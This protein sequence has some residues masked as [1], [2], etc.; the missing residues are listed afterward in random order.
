MSSEVEPGYSD[1]GGH[2][3]LIWG[4]GFLSPGGAAE[5]ARTLAGADI[6]GCEVLDVGSGL[7][8]ADI[9]L[10]R[11]HGAASVIGIDVQEDLVELA[12]RR[13]ADAGLDQRID[14]RLVAP[15]SPLPFADMS[16]DVVFSKDSIIH[17]EDKEALYREA[18]RVLRPGGRLFVSDWLRGEAEELT[19]QVG[20]FVEAAGHL[21]TMISLG[22]AA[23]IVERVGFVG[24]EV[25]DRREWYLDEATS[26]L[27][28][29]RGPLGRQFIERWGEEDA[30]EEVEFWEVLVRSL[31]TGALSP[32]HVRAHKTDA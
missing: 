20:E 15:D 31:S 21:F 3:E 28:R 9:A 4:E 11:V 7:G 32:G 27:A 30:Q 22:E 14:Y 29:L 23:A 10:A 19:P 26:E 16:F 17:V 24:V 1:G 8:G 5:V 2:L 25:E 6:G 13:A 12:G 18:F